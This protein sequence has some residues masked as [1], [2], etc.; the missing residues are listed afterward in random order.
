MNHD[1][2]LCNDNNCKLRD[3]CQRF[4]ANLYISVNCPEE[5]WWTSG[6]YDARKDTCDLYLPN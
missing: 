4:I 2:T 1:F 6:N 5:Y 3:T